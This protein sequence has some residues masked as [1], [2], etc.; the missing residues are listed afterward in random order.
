MRVIRRYGGRQ[1]FRYEHEWPGAQLELAGWSADA[2][3]EGLIQ[4]PEHLLFVTFLGLTERTEALIEGSPRYTGADFPGAVTFVPANRERRAWH[5]GGHIE[6][7]TIR[8]D[9]AHTAAAA[10]AAGEHARGAERVEYVG[11]TNRPD[12]FVHQVA[13]AL[14]DEA[15]SGGVGGPL[16]VDSLTTALCW[17]LLRRYS[18]LAP[19]E[20]HTEQALAGSRLSDVIAYIHDELDGDLRLERLCALAGMDRS[21]FCRA[22]KRAT[23]RPPH[24]YVLEQRVQRASELLAGSRRPIAE[25]ALAVGFSSQSHLTTAFRKITGA[26]P[27]AYRLARRG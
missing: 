26:T 27:H 3:A 17:H 19:R 1:L 7:A 14:R 8:L 15:V 9:P 21:R 23:G 18:G 24:S 16:F 2:G 13:L 22:F 6:Y 4:L 20:Q 25:V 10:V 5:R 12:P 11:F